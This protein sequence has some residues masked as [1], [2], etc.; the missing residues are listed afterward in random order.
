VSEAKAVLGGVDTR[1]ADHP[2]APVLTLKGMTVFGGIEVR[3]AG[4]PTR[5]D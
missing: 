2:E 4:R 5:D 1:G 3:P